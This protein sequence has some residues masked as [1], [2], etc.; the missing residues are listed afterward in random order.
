META[1]NRMETPETGKIDRGKKTKKKKR[2]QFSKR[3]EFGTRD[4]IGMQCPSCGSRDI[5]TVKSEMQSEAIRRRRHKCNRC[6]AAWNSLETVPI[7]DREDI[8]F[9]EL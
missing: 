5:K 8:V 6:P 1:K 2:P 3:I 4:Y 7:A 9:S